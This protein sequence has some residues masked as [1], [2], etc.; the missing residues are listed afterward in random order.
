M[1]PASW[2]VVI[3]CI[4]ERSA[5]RA[6]MQVLRLCF[7]SPKSPCQ[8]SVI[9]SGISPRAIRSMEAAATRTGATRVSSILLR[10][11]ISRA[12]PPVYLDGSAR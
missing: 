11:V 2:E 7:S 1:S 10:S 4:S 12:L 9:G 6:P 3:L 8:S 5:V